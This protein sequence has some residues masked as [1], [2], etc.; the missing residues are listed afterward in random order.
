MD[1]GFQLVWGLL[2]LDTNRLI[3]GGETIICFKTQ[4]PISFETYLN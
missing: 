4:K 1:F 3:S 2:C